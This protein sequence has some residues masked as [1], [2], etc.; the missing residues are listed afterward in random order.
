MVEASL[1]ICFA[2]LVVSS[3]VSG[4]SASAL[5]HYPSKNDRLHGIVVAATSWT[6]PGILGL[7]LL[8]PLAIV[9]TRRRFDLFSRKSAADA[10]VVWSRP[11]SALVLNVEVLFGIVA[12]AGGIFRIIPWI[13]D[14]SAQK[15][16]ID[17]YAFLGQGLVAI[18]LGG[19]ALF[20]VV[21]LAD[22]DSALRDTP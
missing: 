5:L 12:I 7:F 1:L 3:V 22:G 16:A 11:R 6:D 19:I 21:Q 18:V 10:L 9:W 2:V 15:R 14:S 17:T 13:K 4:V 20:I 8:A